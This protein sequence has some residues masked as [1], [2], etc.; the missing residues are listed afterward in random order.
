MSPKRVRSFHKKKKT[1]PVGFIPSSPA[2]RRRP[3]APKPRVVAGRRVPTPPP[4]KSPRPPARPLCAP[5]ALLLAL[6]HSLLPPSRELRL[7]PL[8]PLQLQPRRAR[9]ARRPPARAPA[10]QHRAA[11]LDGNVV[12]AQV[13]AAGEV[14]EVDA[15]RVP[16][17]GEEPPLLRR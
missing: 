15:A 17:P 1:V 7:P 5:A 2:A 14:P 4:P 9:G 11:V 8:L 6:E 13:L 3:V 10:P 16:A 12:G